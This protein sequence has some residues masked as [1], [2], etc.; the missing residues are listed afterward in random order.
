MLV[1]SRRVGESM[2]IGEDVTITILRVK[3]DHVRLGI[4][5]PKE[6]VVQREEVSGRVNPD[7]TAVAIQVSPAPAATGE[8]ATPPVPAR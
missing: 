4:D 5:A 3:G 2:T 6:V 7:V 8:P 1:L